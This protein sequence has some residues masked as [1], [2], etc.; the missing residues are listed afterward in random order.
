MCSSV[1][2]CTACMYVYDHIA[3]GCCTYAKEKYENITNGIWIIKLIRKTNQWVCFW[4][5]TIHILFSSFFWYSVLFLCYFWVARIL[6]TGFFFFLSVRILLFSR[7]WWLWLWLSSCS[8]V[9]LNGYTLQNTFNILKMFWE[10]IFFYA[11]ISPE[12]MRWKWLW[13]FKFRCDDNKKKINE[14]IFF[15]ESTHN[16]NNNNN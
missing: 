7:P 3:Y 10:I 5:D 12:K 13:W 4:F 8:M 2:V 9:P 6:Y 14:N 1:C 16:K 15:L 11:K